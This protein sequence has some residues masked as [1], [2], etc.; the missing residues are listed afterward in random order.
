MGRLGKSG[1]RPALRLTEEAPWPTF[2]AFKT[3]RRSIRGSI[4]SAS[5]CSL[6]ALRERRELGGGSAPGPYPK[7]LL[8]HISRV[9][10][11]VSKVPECDPGW[12]QGQSPCPT[13]DSGETTRRNF[14]DTTPLLQPGGRSP[15]SQGRALAQRDGS[16]AGLELK[17]FE[18]PPCARFAGF[19]PALPAR[20]P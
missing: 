11:A 17:A 16:K 5:S 6:E 3:R 1:R 7:A 8:S 14:F 19:I 13:L 18:S 12:Q 4:A 20:S 2:R 9:K 15:L 10:G